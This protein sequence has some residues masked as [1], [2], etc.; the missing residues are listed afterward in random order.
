MKKAILLLAVLFIFLIQDAW[1]TGDLTGAW[2]YKGEDGV[3][4]DYDFASDGQGT[5][6]ATTDKG[7]K[8]EC[9]FKYALKDVDAK[10][11]LYTLV[12][13]PDKK[14]RMVEVS[15]ITFLL[16]DAIQIREI[17]TYIIE[18]KD[19]SLY[20]L[21]P[22]PSLTVKPELKHLFNIT[23]ITKQILSPGLE[24]QPKIFEKINIS[25]N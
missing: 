16:K 8:F 22:L 1:A 25:K 7:D 23:V 18:K 3:V 2:Q 13:I 20:L 24:E 12:E 15:E 6:A 19:M 10:Q 9:Q 17:N 21:Y 11:C 5:A 4:V 14:V